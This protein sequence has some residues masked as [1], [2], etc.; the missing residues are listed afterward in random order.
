MANGLEKS[1]GLAKT[2]YGWLH[3]DKISDQDLDRDKNKKIEG[4]EIV[5]YVLSH[6][7]DLSDKIKKRLEARFAKAGV[8][9]N[10]LL[11]G[12]PRKVSEALVQKGRE[13]EAAAAKA[14]KGK[15]SGDALIAHQKAKECYLLAVELDPK[16]SAAHGVYAEFLYREG[17]RKEGKLHLREAIRSETTLPGLLTLKDVLSRCDSSVNPWDFI[18]S[19]LTQAKHFSK[20]SGF[21][22]E[23]AVAATAAGKHKLS[24]QYT[25][26]SL[27]ANELAKPYEKTFT[28]KDNR[29]AD[30]L[31][32]TLRAEG[33]PSAT[34]DG[35]TPGEMPSNSPD[36]KITA[37]EVFAYIDSNLGDPR[38]QRALK[39]CGLAVPKLKFRD[40]ADQEAFGRL[41]FSQKHSLY[42]QR[43]AEASANA[44]QKEKHLAAAAHFDPSSATKARALAE[45]HA[46]Q[47]HQD[48][49]IAAYEQLLQLEPSNM[50]DRKALG[51]LYLAQDRWEEAYKVLPRVEAEA[52]LA[53]KL[54]KPR[55]FA[56]I[57]DFDT[58][59]AILKKAANLLEGPYKN[60]ANLPA[61]EASRILRLKAQLDLAAGTVQTLE[62]GAGQGVQDFNQAV[63]ASTEAIQ[64]NPKDIEAYMIR[65]KAQEKLGKDAA[66]MADYQAAIKLTPDGILGEEYYRF[67][68]RYR[69]RLRGE[70]N[71]ELDNFKR[72][73]YETGD[74]E[75]TLAAS[76]LAKLESLAKTLKDFPAGT[77]WEK[78]QDK[79]MVREFYKLRVE[80]QESLGLLNYVGVIPDEEIKPQ[81]TATVIL[82]KIPGGVLNLGGGSNLEPVV[83]YIKQAEAQNA[84]VEAHESKLQSIGYS[85]NKAMYQSELESLEDELRQFRNRLLPSLEPKAG[86]RSSLEQITNAEIV[87][88]INRELGDYVSLAATLDRWKALVDNMS[89]NDLD[90]AYR[91]EQYSMIVKDWKAIGT[92]DADSYPGL[93]TSTEAHD[94][95]LSIFYRDTD[96]K[97]ALKKYAEQKGL[98][99][100][101]KAFDQL[102]HA[103]IG[104][105]ETQHTRLNAFLSAQGIELFFK[106]NQQAQDLEKKS[107]ISNQNDPQGQIF[108][109]QALKLYG[110]LANVEKAQE[111]IEYISDQA[112]YKNAEGTSDIEMLQTYR[113]MAEALQGSAL[114]VRTDDGYE[115]LE[116]SV[117]KEARRYAHKLIPSYY[118]DSATE[119]QGMVAARGFFEWDRDAASIEEIDKKMKEGRT[120]LRNALKT[121]L[122]LLES[123]SEKDARSFGSEFGMYS[124]DERQGIVRRA[125]ALVEADMA[126]LP[127]K[128]I[129]KK[130]VR[131]EMGREMLEH[132]EL[133]RRT[134]EATP[135]L[136]ANFKI[137]QYRQLAATYALYKSQFTEGEMALMA[138]EDKPLPE[139]ASRDEKMK[140]AWAPPSLTV[141][142]K[143][144][145]EMGKTILEE[146]SF[147]F[148]HR[149]SPDY[150]FVIHDVR[151]RGLSK[152]LEEGILGYYVRRSENS[153]NPGLNAKDWR[154][155]EKI[156]ASYKSEFA[157]QDMMIERYLREVDK[158]DPPTEDEQNLRTK[159][160]ADFQARLDLALEKG[161]AEFLSVLSPQSFRAFSEE[162]IQGYEKLEEARNS[163]LPIDERVRASTEAAAVFSQIGVQ[164]RIDEALGTVKDYIETLTGPQKATYYFGLT[165]I[166]EKTGN[167]D[168]AKT[169]LQKL[170]DLDPGADKTKPADKALHEIATYAKAK[171]QIYER[172]LDEAKKF[173]SEIPHNEAAKQLLADIDAV[174]NQQRIGYPME[175][176]SG[177]LMAEIDKRRGTNRESLDY[178]FKTKEEADKFMHK[179]QSFLKEA[180]RLCDSG[181][182]KSLNE[183]LAKMRETGEYFSVFHFLDSTGRG[184]D[185][186]AYIKTMENGSLTDVQMAG[187]TLRLAEQLLNRDDFGFSMEVAARLLDDPF[188]SK[189]AKDLVKSRI[190]DAAKAKARRDA[191]W[192]AVKDIL[193]VPAIVEGRYGD[194]F[195]S[196]LTT[197]AS[198][199]VGRIFSAGAKL[200]WA[201]FTARSALRVGMMARFAAT[202]PRLFRVAEVGFVAMADNAGFTIGGM[203]M[204]TARTGKNQ[205][206]WDRFWHEMALGIAPFGLV[207]VSGRVMG[208]I[209]KRAE[210][211]PWLKVATEAEVILLKGQGKFAVTSGGRAG[212]WATHR[213]MNASAFTLGGLVNQGVG[214]AEKD[215]VPL[216]LLFLQNLA[217]DFQMQAAHKG[218]NALTGGRMDKL[219]RKLDQE[220][221]LAPSLAKLKIP[222]K[223]AAGKAMSGFL[224]HYADAQAGKRG[225]PLSGAEL[226]KEIGA[227]NE[228]ALSFLKKGGLN[229]GDGFEAARIQLFI[230]AASK[231][232]SAQDLA[233]YAERMGTIEGLDRMAAELLP[234][235]VFS[236]GDREAMK[237]NLLL[238]A[239]DRSV[240]P[241]HAKEKMQKFNELAPEINK[242]LHQA[243]EGL[244][245]PGSAHTPQ[246]KRLREIFLARALEAAR[247]PSEAAA[248]LAGLAQQGP[249]LG[250]RIDDL[251][252]V[253]R[254]EDPRARLALVE[255]ATD[256]G[257][258]VAAF[259]Y[260]QKEVLR[261]EVVLRFADGQIRAERV[262]TEAQAEHKRLAEEALAAWRKGLRLIREGDG[263]LGTQSVYRTKVRTATGERTV[264][265]RLDPYAIRDRFQ[266]RAEDNLKNAYQ[267]I[268]L[269]KTYVMADGS[270]LTFTGEILGQGSTST[271]FVAERIRPGQKPERV[272]VK[273]RTHA[274]RATQKALQEKAQDEAEIIQELAKIDPA[275][276]KSGLMEVEGGRPALVGPY[277]DPQ[278]SLFFTRIDDLPRDK[279]ASAQ[280]QM[281]DLISQVASRGHELGDVEFVLTKDGK[282]HL[283]D[284]EGFMRNQFDPQDQQARREAIDSMRNLV[285]LSDQTSLS[286]P[287]VPTD[288]RHVSLDPARFDKVNMSERV[289]KAVLKYEEKAGAPIS[290]AALQTLAKKKPSEAK[291]LLKMAELYRK[292]IGTPLSGPVFDKLV[293][294]DVEEARPII[295]IALKNKG[296]ES[297]VN[298]KKI[299][300]TGEIEGIGSGR[301]VYRGYTVEGGKKV[302]VA[303]KMV[304]HSLG[305][306]YET[307]DKE[308]RALQFFSDNK[309][310]EVHFYGEPKFIGRKGREKVPALV[311][312]LAEG[313]VMTNITTVPEA[314]R[315]KVAKMVAHDMAMASEAG[316]NMGGDIQFVLGRDANGEPRVQWIDLESV[317]RPHG[318]TAD[319][320]YQE[321]IKKFLGEE[322]LQK[323][324]N[325]IPMDPK[326][327]I[328][329]GTETG[330]TLKAPP[331]SDSDHAPL[332]AGEKKTD[333]GGTVPQGDGKYWLSD[334]TGVK[335]PALKSTLT[336]LEEK[337][338]AIFAK[339]PEKGTVR[340]TSEDYSPDR[341][342]EDVYQ[343]LERGK[344]LDLVTRSEDLRKAVEEHT[345]RVVAE[346]EKLYPKE[347]EAAKDR[348]PYT[349][350]SLKKYEARYRFAMMLLNDKAGRPILGEPSPKEKTFVVNFVSR[351]LKVEGVTTYEGAQKVLREQ[352]P[353]LSPEMQKAFRAAKPAERSLLLDTFF[354]AE[355]FRSF[356]DPQAAFAFVQFL[357]KTGL[358]REIGLFVDTSAA[359]PKFYVGLGDQSAVS[360]PGSSF[361]TILHTHPHLYLNKDFK[362]MGHGDVTLNVDAG[363]ISAYSANV[364]FSDVDVHRYV[365]EARTMEKSG[366][367]DSV[368]YDRQTRVF[369]NWVQHP[370]GVSEVQ[371]GLAANGKDV[372]SVK[373]RYGFYTNIKGLDQSHHKGAETLKKELQK[374]Y[375]GAA[376]EVNE[377]VSAKIEKDL[378]VFSSKPSDE[379]KAPAPVT[380]TVEP[381]EEFHVLPPQFNP[382][383][384]INISKKWT[385]KSADENRMVFVSASGTHV[386]LDRA[387]RPPVALQAGESKKPVTSPPRTFQ[388]PP[389]KIRIIIGWSPAV[390]NSDKED[391]YMVKDPRIPEGDLGTLVKGKDG[392]ELYNHSPEGFLVNGEKIGDSKKIKDGDAIV[393]LT[394]RE[395]EK[396]PLFV[397]KAPEEVPEKSGVHKIGEIKVDAEALNLL[398][399]LDTVPP[400]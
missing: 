23:A 137:E 222:P 172:N 217:M 168:A 245:G 41:S 324:P 106:L 360:G 303:I 136:P 190:P 21:Y 345:A 10:Q 97:G 235:E 197:V 195:I 220:L 293:K 265:V 118:P 185:T 257:F 388:P 183:A 189:Q 186:L 295:E 71:N 171:L 241:D 120:E 274:G 375:P 54:D 268:D 196:A 330:T 329:L 72:F 227:L 390:N 76:S 188:V 233:W 12:E 48:Q 342:R 247:E 27:L 122:S 249:L 38:V 17:N 175:F 246:G 281:E 103:I 109:L 230:H 24:I 202:A 282:L 144:I 19:E 307:R 385:L 290:E 304:S 126:V 369:K 279:Q 20:A 143:A 66:A 347:F 57:K 22:H 353:R 275:Y 392:W 132:L 289:R 32:Q 386:I 152:H 229:S 320:A 389:G 267:S 338:Q 221:Y 354:G 199:G 255:L 138:K 306:G 61:D 286:L 243:V 62:K 248:L 11:P 166:F 93:P 28:A 75:K 322:F 56:E 337:K 238:W 15:Q 192:K 156:Q 283:L 294:Y 266:G 366:K 391:R 53:A 253:N 259:D 86:E 84:R 383:G 85:A 58:A 205:F 244:L 236:K 130:E 30:R 356:E 151:K 214:L 94:R 400:K 261:G 242:N 101:E 198:F 218:V 1:N 42:H 341:V 344:S 284:V 14:K 316:L 89:P 340:G 203:M 63:E 160:Q 343:V 60:R 314:D 164:S 262:P 158:F 331:T 149:L 300:F 357:G 237:A 270:S 211:I 163:N 7:K 200:A 79:K 298:G 216:G 333:T 251:V 37:A 288:V 387:D 209:G 396:I 350:E 47:N 263:D 193:I 184:K 206:S 367:S 177:V 305:T 125:S 363:K 371:V 311:T 299:V 9:A 108:A 49:A 258:D 167:D 77:D 113:A 74:A 91:L 159:L 142:G 399:S 6:F 380:L 228:S 39:E 364:L 34:I 296:E 204:D 16:N 181:E 35:S 272:S 292:K 358:H 78:F 169:S 348:N 301:T 121:T 153:E 135:D 346:A 133:W 334:F 157:L 29:E 278:S 51:Q 45:F 116:E 112:R 52:M 18:G 162:A 100:D 223:S 5:S 210:H 349:G 377:T 46:E 90:L 43:Q 59:R 127:T 146:N 176:L 141:Q 104:G 394:S 68:E 310:G 273:V 165:Q 280:T 65:A 276:A 36:R 31:Y 232:M 308:V 26:K 81:S 191:I 123:P 313:E 87:A 187:E 335:D 182:C 140:A 154:E 107:F 312:N 207:H 124:I 373:I 194:A 128:D 4:E 173:L 92:L 161:D 250:Q 119:V 256:K 321:A 325:L 271:I 365:E 368:I 326:E 332:P 269:N 252:A 105:D 376:I 201:G 297:S 145:Q 378:P 254:L 328:R 115:R 323:N 3:H 155:I 33:I 302:P 395:G 355:R 319:Q 8:D 362:P 170:A 134:I 178:H 139:D 351:A 287:K 50:A 2:F 69:E 131:E 98:T 336:H 83:N 309:I 110:D 372:K 327:A 25:E 174:Q 361:Y 82:D 226:A 393:L 114:D 215:N 148:E 352:F 339:I 291:G 381:K 384:D 398:D 374:K 315:A 96:L 359:P 212:L 224:H 88:G 397:F 44:K 73:R 234:A 70:F 213:L 102:I 231:N 13:W 264:E 225:K 80:F 95:I 382:K 240:H 147:A 179:A 40:A 117:L 277:F 208:A 260:L 239:I 99:W 219:D 318:T 55:Q 150:Y 111:L 64:K 317:G 180:Q 285:G 67:T 379:A 129:S 370:F